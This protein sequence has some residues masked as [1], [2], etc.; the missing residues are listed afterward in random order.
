[1]VAHHN[2]AGN[3]H[4]ARKETTHQKVLDEYISVR[5]GLNRKPENETKILT[6]EDRLYELSDSLKPKVNNNSH[7]PLSNP[8]IMHKIR[9]KKSKKKE[10]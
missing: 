6:D 9:R 2:L 5:L 3:E 10:H 1:M 4:L 8:Q 7:K